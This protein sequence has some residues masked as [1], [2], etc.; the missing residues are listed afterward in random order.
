MMDPTKYAELYAA[1]RT[2]AK[3]I[4]ESPLAVGMYSGSRASLEALATTDSPSYI[5]V[6]LRLSGE[7]LNTSCTLCFKWDSLNYDADVHEDGSTWRT[8]KTLCEVNWP[9]HG[10]CS[11]AVAKERMDFYAQCI[12]LAAAIES[13]TV[14]QVEICVRT[15]EEQKAAEEA[16]RIR[17][18]EQK[19]NRALREAADVVRKGMRVNQ[20]RSVPMALLSG[21]AVGSYKFTC[22][23]YGGKVERRFNLWVPQYGWARLTRL[24]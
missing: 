20:D 16:T 14:R 21:V 17:I 5:N 3:M 6:D 15:P 19:L 8:Y 2:A 10:S 23:D 22:E 13:A 24:S 1:I 11:P 4:L 12:E 7:T 18:A 9:S